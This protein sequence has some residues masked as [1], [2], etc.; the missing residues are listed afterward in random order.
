MQETSWNLAQLQ[1]RWKELLLPVAVIACLFIIF[2]PLPAAAMDM[3]LATNIAVA[4]VI[5]LTTLFVRTPLEF[6][7]FPSL[8]LI[9]T[10]GRLSLNIATTRLILSNGATDQELAAG[11]LIQS[12]GQFV[13]GDHIA[14]GLVIFAIIVIIQF[15]V[16][17]RGA[18][19]ISEVTARFALDG[20]PGRQMSID[21]DLNAG[22]IDAAQ[23]RE[24]R[25]RL[26]ASADF[27][28]AMDGASK[29]VRGD[30]VAGILITF[31]NIIGGLIV[32][33]TANMSL[34]EAG[35]V[36]TKL[37][38]GDG[39]SSQL[40]ALFTS[41]AA[42]MLVTRPAADSNLPKDSFVQLTGKPAVLVI[43]AVFL[44]A[45]LFTSLPKIPLLL[46]AVA[47]LLGARLLKSEPTVKY[48]SAE[49]NHSKTPPKSELTIDRLLGNEILEMELGIDLIPLADPKHGGTLLP[50]VTKIRKSLASDLGVILPKI[51]IKDNLQLPQKE[52]RI[53]VQGNPID[54]GTIFPDL[55]LATDIGHSSGPIQGAVATETTTEG[56]AFWIP[57]ENRADAERL[58]YKIAN[59]STVLLNRLSEIAN[60]NAADLLTRDATNELIEE[61]R[62][63]SPAIVNELLPELIDLKQ[64]QRILKQL[65]S[66][67]V[68][69]RP[70][71]LILETI[72]DAHSQ[73]KHD[74]WGLI[75]R[76]RQTLAPQITSRHLNGSH[77]IK[78][79]TI[80]EDLQTEIASKFRVE[81]ERIQ[82]TFSREALKELTTSLSQAAES[83]RANQ[84]LPVLCVRQDIRPAVSSLVR[85]H[86]ID[87]TV[88]GS[89]EIVG[90]YVESIGEITTEQFRPDSAAA[91]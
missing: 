20:M 34:P 21:A 73:G 48:G 32:G 58:G 52:Y 67:N 37:T 33:I 74:H 57:P 88:L 84:L 53:L 55:L 45:M 9:T 23:A 68:S 7:V 91:A 12:F 61:T 41:I 35:S 76:I 5:L 39:L 80:A 19:R 79:L 22:V 13:A 50:A 43:T 65:V 75:E 64:L 85:N 83:M 47:C 31:V 69:I 27:Y 28:G 15:V 26:S 24:L 78:A 4:V 18:T 62:K 66:E 29:F 77:A 11:Q 54:I 30:A 8:I 89:R 87:L 81:D 49:S 2:V 16:I 36:F 40:P 60:Q 70:L 63:S 86:E 51:R 56:Q 72:G 38:I 17:T 10:V 82:N 44:V 1:N 3:L 71:G 46:L 59:A 25:Q 6:S 42:A 14:I 90:T